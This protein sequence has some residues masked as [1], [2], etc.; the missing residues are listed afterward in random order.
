M[1]MSQRRKGGREALIPPLLFSSFH[2]TE[3]STQRP[4]PVL[5]CIEPPTYPPVCKIPFSPWLQKALTSGPNAAEWVSS[6]CIQGWNVSPLSRRQACHGGFN[7]P[8]GKS[9]IAFSPWSHRKDWSGSA[10]A[11]FLRPGI[12]WLE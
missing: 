5:D 3:P 7:Q 6:S 2:S 1:N 12:T 4:C 10:A 8:G 11:C 9:H